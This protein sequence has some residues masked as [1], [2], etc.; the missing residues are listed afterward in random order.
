M[1]KNKIEPLIEPLGEDTLEQAIGMLCNIFPYKEL[2]EPY[3]PL[4][5]RVRAG[6]KCSLEPNASELFPKISY[7]EVLIANYW[8]LIYDKKVVGVT[9]LY[10]CKK[11]ENE[12]LWLGWFAVHPE[13][14][15][16]GFAQ[17]L[18]NFTVNEVKNRGFKVFRAYTSNY[19]NERIANL[20]YQKNEFNVIGEMISPLK[21]RI[22]DSE[23]LK[24]IFLEKKI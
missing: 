2:T 20:F 12:A 19:R 11:D 13:Y 3:W 14:R 9:G 7:G 1:L 21:E 10:K 15:R 8:T 16:R 5:D 18:M 4:S 6:L 22:D 17:T 24:L 23:F